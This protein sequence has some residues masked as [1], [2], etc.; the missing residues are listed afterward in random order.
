MKDKLNISV[1]K[2]IKEEFT[3][4]CK[5]KTINRSAWLENKMKEFIKESKPKK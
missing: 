3:R 5:E 2:D 1:E 4:V